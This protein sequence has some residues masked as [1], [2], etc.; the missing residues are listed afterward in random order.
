MDSVEEA[1]E[2]PRLLLATARKDSQQLK[3]LLDGF[4]HNP[5]PP[6]RIIVEPKFGG[7]VCYAE[8]IRKPR[9]EMRLVS[10]TIV[11]NLRNALDHALYGASRALGQTKPE[12]TNFP[13]RG[14]PAD[15]EHVFTAKG[16]CRD[17]PSALHDVLRSFQPYPKGNGYAGGDDALIHLNR[18]ANPNKHQVALSIQ[19]T[20]RDNTLS[21]AV[22][23]SPGALIVPIVPPR[24]NRTKDKL[25]IFEVVK[26]PT[27]NSDTIKVDF[28]FNIK[29]DASVVLSEPPLDGVSIEGFVSVQLDKVKSIV[30]R[31]EVETR[32]LLT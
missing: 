22:V 26:S 18:L 6:C 24:W 11:N 32:K 9:S 12:K 14:S 2:S 31:L 19:P 17:V 23:S 15:L 7:V 8:V 28:N 16:M 30:D 29:V 3:A 1:F 20:L 10:Y 25:A 27:A 4:F 5:D 21:A 13:F